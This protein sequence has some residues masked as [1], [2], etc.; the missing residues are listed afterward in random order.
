MLQPQPSLKVTV[1]VVEAP[2]DATGFGTFVALNPVAGA[3]EYVP[4]PPHAETPVAFKVVVPPLQIVTS[5][6]AST[7][8]TSTMTVSTAKQVGSLIS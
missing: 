3:Q 4:P 6:P 1:Y 2:G 5:S 8:L 7:V